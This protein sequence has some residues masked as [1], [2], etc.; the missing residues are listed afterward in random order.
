MAQ[1]NE[2]DNKTGRENQSGQQGK[3]GNQ[4]QPT[5]QTDQ[6]RTSQEQRSASE[7]GDTRNGG[8]RSSFP[9][10][11]GTT[12]SGNQEFENPLCLVPAVLSCVIKV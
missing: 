8:D 11:T 12:G 2:N 10:G 1:Q 5:G 3:T 4:N 9:S 7:K 6:N